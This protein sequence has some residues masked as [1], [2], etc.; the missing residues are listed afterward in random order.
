MIPLFKVR[1]S[2]TI[3]EELAPT[4]IS[5]FIAQG[6]RV[7][8]LEKTLH[9]E[10]SLP[11]EP[12][13][14]NSATSAIDL[15]LELLDI[16]PGDEVISTPMTCFASNVGALKRGAN[17]VWADVSPYT[18]LIDVLDVEEKI[19]AK[20]KAIIAVDWAGQFADYEG[21]K[22]LGVPVIEDS[23]HVWDTFDHGRERGDFIVYSLQA[24]KFLTA[25]DGGLLVTPPEYHKAARDLRWYGLDRDNNENFRATQDIKRAGFKYNMNDVN[26]SIALAN[27]RYAR[28]SVEVHRKNA[29]TLHHY[30][31]NLGFADPVPWGKASSYWI[32][33]LVFHRPL[34]RDHFER[35]M[36]SKGIM[37]AQVHFRNDMYSVTEQ[38][39]Q[40][41]P[42]LDS[43]SSNQ[44]NIPCGWWLS[45][46]D[47]KYI[48]EAVQEFGAPSGA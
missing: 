28:N 13:A 10:L 42:G 23:A 21:L 24:I 27:I 14:V 1:M 33:P 47:L 5:G 44:T 3:M 2:P 32:F 30:L 36:K 26:A 19:T 34:D 22:S 29:T 16:G 46:D 38:F 40:D 18:G 20:T 31:Q 12:V 4:L 45:T 43:F 37:S 35:Y 11:N 17:I 9:M 7:E 41:L 25:A 15:A 8:A 48:I 39:K 6:P